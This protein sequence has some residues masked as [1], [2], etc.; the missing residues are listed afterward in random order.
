MMRSH[1]P[2]PTSSH[3]PIGHCS[4]CIGFG[5]GVCV[6]VGQCE[7][8]IRA[9]EVQ[10]PRTNSAGCAQHL[11]FQ[12]S[13][14]ELRLGMQVQITPHHTCYRAKLNQFGIGLNVIILPKKVKSCRI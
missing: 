2:T 14:F 8:T 10:R 4:D 12:K 3:I 11:C 5:L 1:C 13:D 6:G 9:A 7:H